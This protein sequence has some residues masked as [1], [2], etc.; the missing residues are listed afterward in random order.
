MTWLRP[1]LLQATI[2]PQIGDWS[3]TIYPCPLSFL[4]MAID[5]CE[6]TAFDGAVGQSLPN[7][8]SPDNMI[9]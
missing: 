7:S 4:Q 6:I 5:L 8:Y 1:D 9:A 2:P 3:P